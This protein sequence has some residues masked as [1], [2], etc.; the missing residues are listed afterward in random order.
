MNGRKYKTSKAQKKPKGLKEPKES[1][2][3]KIL[4]VLLCE[5]DKYYIGTTN[6]NLNI[7][8][9][10]HFSGNG[11]FFT[12][13]YKPIK[14]VE[15]VENVDDFDE[16]KY[17][18]VYMKKYGIDNVRGGSYSQLTLEDY[19]VKT[20]ES[21]LSTSENVCF[22]CKRKGHYIKECYAKT[23]VGG[24]AIEDT[25][26]KENIEIKED[27]IDTEIKENI[28]SH[29]EEYGNNDSVDINEC[30]G[31]GMKYVEITNAREKKNTPSFFTKLIFICCRPE[32]PNSEQY[33]KY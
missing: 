28:R 22:R 19:K 20:L 29:I 17:V 8:L 12:K 3:K 27:E 33:K 13:K 23:D 31:P 7:R 11:S 15:L 25:E 32:L 2:E 16:D 18:K 5:N 30:H 14:T 10:E 1:K 4:Y 24:M 21:E 6:R 9:E 26:I